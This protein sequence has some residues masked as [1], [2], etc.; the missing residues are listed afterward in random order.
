MELKELLGDSYKEGMTLDEVSEALKGIELPKDQSGEIEKLRES[1]SKS[2]SE[3]ADWK[4][5]FRATQDEATR[6]AAE[7]EESTK[8]L[9][10]ELEELR[11]ER[12]IAGYKASYL[13]L[14]YAEKDAD[15]I[16]KAMQ[17]GDTTKVL[18][19]QKRHQD[20]LVEKTKQD[21]LKSTPRPGTPGGDPGKDEDENETIRLAREIG[22]AS[23]GGVK[24]A[25]DVLKHYMH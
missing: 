17:E 8:K 25:S 19:I 20:A 18:E 14:G 6:K 10:E 22:K 5:Q 16:A 12:A 13:G 24:T 9:Q 15:E 23:A 4:K 11:K 7:V 2:N 3:A 1:L 21:L